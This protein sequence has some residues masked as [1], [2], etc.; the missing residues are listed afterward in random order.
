MIRGWTEEGWALTASST[1][2]I[3]MEIKINNSTLSLR[4]GHVHCNPAGKC[5]LAEA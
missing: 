4:W 1:V 5:Y 3:N 2:K